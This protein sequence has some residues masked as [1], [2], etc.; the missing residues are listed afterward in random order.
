MRNKLR[1]NLEVTE[2]EY[3]TGILAGTGYHCGS[4]A[5]LSLSE[6]TLRYS[7]APRIC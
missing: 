3:R 6:W 7:K 5:E 4:A 1:Y 2:C